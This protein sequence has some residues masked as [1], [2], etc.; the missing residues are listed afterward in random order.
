MANSGD[1][2]TDKTT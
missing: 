2:R 1:N